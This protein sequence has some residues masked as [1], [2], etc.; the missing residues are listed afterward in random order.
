MKKLILLLSILSSVFAAQN[1][2]Y[3]GFGLGYGALKVDDT[4][5]K[6]RD[7]SGLTASFALGHKY[8]EYGRIY[9]VGMYRGASNGYE[10]SGS[11]S[12]AY[13]FLIP[14]VDDSFSL[15]LGPVA[16]Y[17]GYST[18]GL[19]LSGYHYGLESGCIFNINDSIELEAGVRVLK[20]KGTEG[21]FTAERSI[22]GFAQVNFYFESEKWF[23]YKN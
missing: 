6:N 11:I 9:V 1:S 4:I 21:A 10:N 23:T 3:M 20:E 8:S 18:N 22:T 16:G 12:L 2:S 15:Y 7:S 19:D 5:N 14:V 13:D 17:T